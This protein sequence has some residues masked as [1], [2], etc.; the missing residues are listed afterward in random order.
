MT[1]QI[2]RIC[3][4]SPFGGE[5]V[6]EVVAGTTSGMLNPE[7]DVDVAVGAD[8]TMLVYTPKSGCP[9]AKQNAVL[10][11]LRSDASA[12]SAQELLDSLGL[13]ELAERE[14]FLVVFPNSL[15][16]GWNYSQ[17]ASLDDDAQFIVRCFAALP[18]S[19]GGVAGF[20]GMIYHLAVDSASSAMAVSL[21]ATHP[22]DAA[23]IMVGAL[24]E[25]YE[26]PTGSDAEQVA[27]SY[28]SDERV[29][30]WITRVN[31]GV[32]VDVPCEGVECWQAEDN[33]SVMA[34]A[35]NEGLSATVVERAWGLMFART[36]RWRNDTFGTYQPRI[37][38]A[39]RGFV[40]HIDDDS[41]LGDGLA[42]TWY[43]YVPE[44]LRGTD[45]EIPLVI[46]LHGINCIATYGAEQSGWAD[47]A[48]RDGF[49]CAF[50]NPTIEERWN[51][52][53]DSRL[54]A[55]VAYILEIIER[56]AAVHPIDRS[57]IYLSGFSMGSMFSNALA[58]SYPDVF[59]GVVA[60]NGPHVGYLQ[61]LDEAA[62]GMLMFR[63]NSVI[64]DIPAG[65]GSPAPT[66][67]LADS[68][69]AAFD[70]RMPVVQFV[71][72][73]D[74]VG[75]APKRLWPVSGVEGD[76]WLPTV[77][78]WKAFNAIEASV[79]D[80]STETGFAGESVVDGRFVH[81][82]WESADARVAGADDTPEAAQLYHLI[83]LRRMPHA[84]DLRAIEIGWDIVK[85]YRRR[86]DGSL[87][88]VK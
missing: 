11:V 55:D 75:C 17:D 69:K 68:K 24:P 12:E 54:P 20:N 29:A 1:E 61:T 67:A 80:A 13:A 81:Q 58:C 52:W 5:L 38:F 48:D 60:C 62:P 88:Y 78:Y 6:E 31:A 28:E 56:M 79:L 76:M 57:R 47:L 26:I 25:G 39:A 53:D 40:A 4:F 65:D 2:E 43:E 18:K 82:K 45:E 70:Y 10:M 86:A 59:A 36:R 84:V 46:Y 9:H 50:P 51:A 74:G 44:Q 3:K 8:R 32:A 72:L 66:H 37:D 35:S 16:S 27:W 42:R 21:A 33:P 64:R 85:H 14:H 73:L 71:G 83:A 30:S 77:D 41:L 87:G 7:N 22:L 15:A 49:M 23:A 63:P 19:K 34:F